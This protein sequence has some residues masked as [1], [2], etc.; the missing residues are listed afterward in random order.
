MGDGFDASFVVDCECTL[1]FGG[2]N[3]RLHRRRL[4]ISQAELARQ[5]TAL[6]GLEISQ[7]QISRWE[8]VRRVKTDEAG[9][10]ALRKVLGI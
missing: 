10:R 5:L 3:L 7:M 8:R 9:Y 1:Y 6:T 2:E 4:G